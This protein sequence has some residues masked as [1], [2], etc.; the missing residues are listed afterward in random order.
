MRVNNKMLVP[1][2]PLPPPPLP[3]QEDDEED[4]DIYNVPEY[5]VYV[6]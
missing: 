2:P 5:F 3:P 1:S 6:I 4:L